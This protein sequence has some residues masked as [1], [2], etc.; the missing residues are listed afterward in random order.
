[1]TKAQVIYRKKKLL[2]FNG[3]FLSEDFMVLARPPII[4]KISMF[5]NFFHLK[6]NAPALIN[7]QNS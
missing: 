4:S 1:M 5:I 6:S 7:H 2:P 3:G